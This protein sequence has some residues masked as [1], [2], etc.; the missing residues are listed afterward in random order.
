MHVAL[1]IQ[2][3]GRI[4]NEQP[5]VGIH[6]KRCHQVM[7]RISASGTSGSIFVQ[8]FAYSSTIIVHG[9]F[10]TYAMYHYRITI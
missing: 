6:L 5:H 3:V 10:L 4:K 9:G 2:P 8:E 7:T 1:S